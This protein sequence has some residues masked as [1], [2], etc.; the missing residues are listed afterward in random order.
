MVCVYWV[1]QYTKNTNLCWAPTKNRYY[2]RCCTY[3]TLFILCKHIWG[4]YDLPLFTDQEKHSRWGTC[5]SSH[6]W[7][8]LELW[9]ESTSPWSQSSFSFSSITMQL[10]KIMMALEVTIV[11]MSMT[12]WNIDAKV[13]GG[14]YGKSNEGGVDIG[15]GAVYGM[16]MPLAGEVEPFSKMTCPS[17]SVLL[18]SLLRRNDGAGSDTFCQEHQFWLLGLES[19]VHIWGNW[20]RIRWEMWGEGTQVEI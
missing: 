7:W 15:E 19:R 18:S 20:G 12:D 2:T 8:E 10:P 17:V 3:L 5:P 6:K 1:P 4:R 9:F 11:L 14:G 16:S 13:S